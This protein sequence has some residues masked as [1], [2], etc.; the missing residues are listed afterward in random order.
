MPEVAGPTRMTERLI[1]RRWRDEDRAPF[2]EMNADPDVMRYFPRLLTRQESDRMID[3]IE[4]RFEADGMAQHCRIC[5]GQARL[6][7]RMHGEGKTLD[8][9]RTAID[10]KF[11]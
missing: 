1:L 8:Q 10:A 3:A 6:A 9:I 5:Q 2:A 11:G 4:A 7:F